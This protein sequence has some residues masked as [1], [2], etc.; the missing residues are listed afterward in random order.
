MAS[1]IPPRRPGEASVFDKTF[2]VLSLLEKSSPD[3]TFEF[4]AKTLIKNTGTDQLL[5]SGDQRYH[6]HSL[7]PSSL[8]FLPDEWVTGLEYGRDRWSGC[9]N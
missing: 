7:K 9:N 4:A 1:R 5:K 8:S 6:V 3:N 2:Q